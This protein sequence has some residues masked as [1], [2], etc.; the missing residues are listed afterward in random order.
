[1]AGKL[2]AGSL[3][4]NNYNVLPVG[5]PFG[6]CKLSGFGRENAADTLNYYSQL[7][8]IYVEMND[9]DCPL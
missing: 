1:M 6:G 5:V 4:I 8:S 3:Y 9:V 7:K 2:E